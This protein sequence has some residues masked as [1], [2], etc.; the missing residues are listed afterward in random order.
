MT[1]EEAI[2]LIQVHERARQGQLRAKLMT[3]IRQEEERQRLAQQQGKPT[4]DLDTAATVIQKV[5][6]GY[7]Q[8]KKTARLR[9]EELIFVGMV[10]PPGPI[11]LKNTPQAVS[12]K[13]MLS[14][15]IA[16]EQNENDYQQALGIVK[17]RLKEVE[18]PDMREHMQDEIRKW[19][20]EVRDATGKFPE[21]PDDEVG[22][23]AAI[24]KKQEPGDE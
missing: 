5:W 2:Q 10:P 23:S 9:A 20:I 13:V 14:R 24:F 6:K 3:N 8:R 22:G 19:F 1:M 4:I 15:R 11:S 17:A 21:Y 12:K 7:S 16:Q 18:G